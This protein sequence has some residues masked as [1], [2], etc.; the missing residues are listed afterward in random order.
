MFDVTST[1]NLKH[2]CQ[3]H[4]HRKQ[5]PRCFRCW[6][7]IT[8][9]FGS[10]WFTMQKVCQA[11]FTMEKKLNNKFAWNFV[12]PMELRLRNHWKCCRTVL[13]SLLYR[14]RKYLSGIKHLVSCKVVKNLPHGSR[15]STTVDDDN[16]EKV[17][18][19]VVENRRVDIREVAEA[20]NI[21]YG[22]T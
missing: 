6:G 9:L 19:I 15:L 21:S 7:S 2:R 8:S 16:I 22:S 11:I 5:K 4:R 3:K 1:S 17:E 18:K 12:F 14:E 20:L 13:G 10:H